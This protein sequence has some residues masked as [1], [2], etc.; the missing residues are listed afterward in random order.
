MAKPTEPTE[1]EHEHAI[2]LLD[3]RYEY[4]VWGK[5]RGARKTLSAIASR[6][7]VE[8]VDDCYFLID[9][10][11]VNAKVRGNALKVKRLVAERKGFEC[12]VSNWHHEAE[13]APAPFDELFDELRLDRP[14]RGKPFNLVKAVDRLD[15]EAPKAIFVTKERRRYRVGSVKAEVTDI[16]IEQTAEVLRTLAIVGDDLDELVALRK[17]LGLRDAENVAVHV[18]IDTAAA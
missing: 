13:T 3:A 1:I 16:T 4:R 18:A 10:P 14:A 2:E 9:E 6:E 12:W 8:R 11:G 7:I 17:R 15:D 5:H